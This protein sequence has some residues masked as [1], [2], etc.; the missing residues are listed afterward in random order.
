MHCGRNVKA[1]QELLHN[2]SN[3]LAGWK[4]TCLSK[5]SLITLPSSVLNSLPI[6]QMQMMRLPMEVLNGLDKLCRHCIWGEEGERKRMHLISR[7]TICRPKYRGG[8]GILK[9]GDINKAMLTKLCWRLL[10]E[11]NSL[12]ARLMKAKYNISSLQ[13][14]HVQ[15]DPTASF[16]WRSM[17]W[18][19]DLLQQ[20]LGKIVRNG[21][22][23]LFWLDKWLD[24]S[25]L[26]K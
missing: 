17:C 6:F 25:T 7:D 16:I 3:R 4:L 10:T 1:P 18:S 22:S 13:T 24:S 26:Q 21:R 15:P 12:W 20:G 9:A 5:A 23:T 11:G 14:V 2:A 19:R 8:L